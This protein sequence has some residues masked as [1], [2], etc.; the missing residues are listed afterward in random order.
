MEQAYWYVIDH[1]LSTNKSY[2][3]VN[4]E[5]KCKY[6][7]S[8]KSISIKS[9]ASVPS[10]SYEKL[11]SAVIQQPVTVAVDSEKFMLYE[12]GV[13]TGDCGISVDRGMLL[14]GYGK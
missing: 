13:Y 8:M 7:P 14:V 4:K 12:K 10:K 5:Q 6:T 9:C 1:G 3:F 11:L 2:P